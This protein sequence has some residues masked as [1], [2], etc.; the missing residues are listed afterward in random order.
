M[1]GIL[2]ECMEILKSIKLHEQTIRAFLI[3][4]QWQLS[5]HFWEQIKYLKKQRRF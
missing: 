4:F 1:N 3:Y 2:Q 5:I